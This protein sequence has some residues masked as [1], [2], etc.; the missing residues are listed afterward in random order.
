MN[1]VRFIGTKIEFQRIFNHQYTSVNRTS[2]ITKK[3]PNKIANLQAVRG[4]ENN[5]KETERGGGEAREEKIEERQHF[6]YL[7]FVQKR[8][9]LRKTN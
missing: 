9:R 4:Q 6:C 1:H 7:L 8:V 5:R 3:S 2:L